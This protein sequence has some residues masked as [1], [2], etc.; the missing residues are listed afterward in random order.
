MGRCSS[1]RN[2]LGKCPPAQN[3]KKGKRL[4]NGSK[5]VFFYILG[6]SSPQIEFDPSSKQQQKVIHRIECVALDIVLSWMF[7]SSIGSNFLYNKNVQIRDF[8]G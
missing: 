4:E 1:P 5:Y 8:Q 7:R 2:C 6:I 3:K